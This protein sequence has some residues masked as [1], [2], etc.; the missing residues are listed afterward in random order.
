MQYLVLNVTEAEGNGRMSRHAIEKRAL[1]PAWRKLRVASKEFV[2]PLML[3]IH[4]TSEDLAGFESPSPDDH[5]KLRLP[6]VGGEQPVMRDF[7]PRCWDADAGLF[8]LE[9]AVHAK[10]PYSPATRLP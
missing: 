10:G 5:V 6:A 9:F 8:T 1:Q 4:F 7:T 2:T 3:R